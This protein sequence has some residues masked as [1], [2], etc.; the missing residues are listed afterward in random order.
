MPNK[1]FI[2]EEK[3]K[4]LQAFKVKPYDIII[5]RSGTVGEICSIPEMITSGI[6]STNLIRVRL[7]LNIISTKYFVYL[8]QGGNVREQVKEL[9][10]GSTRA[11]LN[12]TILSSINF[13]LFPP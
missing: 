10:K 4:E 5:S 12:Q 13:P 11:F 9:C 6:I 1:I 2:T 3:V 8:F 7:N